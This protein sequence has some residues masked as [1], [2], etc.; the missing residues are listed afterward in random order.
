MPNQK[1]N[2]MPTEISTV[3]DSDKVIQLVK[4]LTK[5]LNEDESAIKAKI[6]G[7]GTTG[8]TSAA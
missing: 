5:D 4:D 1:I 2:E 8:R 6:E 3:L 7:N